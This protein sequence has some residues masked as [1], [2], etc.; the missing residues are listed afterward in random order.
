MHKGVLFVGKKR[1]PIPGVEV[2]TNSLLDLDVHV[3]NS[4]TKTEGKQGSTYTQRAPDFT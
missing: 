2:E 1:G 4:R 3:L